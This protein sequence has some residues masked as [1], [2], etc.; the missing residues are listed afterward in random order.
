ML[1]LYR[2]TNVYQSS[3]YARRAE[4][5]DFTNKGFFDINPK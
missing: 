1:F 2:S 4:I 3:L 5:N